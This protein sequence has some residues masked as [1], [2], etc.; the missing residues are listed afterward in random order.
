[1]EFRVDAEPF[2]S[3]T[4]LGWQDGIPAAIFLENTPS[5]LEA[6]FGQEQVILAVEVPGPLPTRENS[7][8]VTPPSNEAKMISISLQVSGSL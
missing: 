2:F 1:M 3:T 4:I 8:T 6:I 5:M 7:A